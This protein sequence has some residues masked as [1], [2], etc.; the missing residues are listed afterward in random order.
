MNQPEPNELIKRYRMTRFL[1]VI[2]LAV[3]LFVLA[4]TNLAMILEAIDQASTASSV[5]DL[6]DHLVVIG[7]Q[8]LLKGVLQA[9]N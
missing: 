7:R 9:R 8:G 6:A 1:M 2:V 5:T 3:Q 4:G